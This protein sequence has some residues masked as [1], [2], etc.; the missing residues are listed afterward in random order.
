MSNL[1]VDKLF[2]VGWS[3]V[4]LLGNQIVGRAPWTF[5]PYEN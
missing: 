3:W 1:P 5:A 2:E 4:K